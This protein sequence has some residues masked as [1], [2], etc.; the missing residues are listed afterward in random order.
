M[1]DVLYPESRIYPEILSRLT[2]PERVALRYLLARR[3]TSQPLRQDT[4]AE[5]IFH[6]YRQTLLHKLRTRSHV[7]LVLMTVKGQ[8]HPRT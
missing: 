2:A 1:D 4:V 7:E 3:S 5:K 8:P 6:H